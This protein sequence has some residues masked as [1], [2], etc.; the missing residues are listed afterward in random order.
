MIRA[1]RGAAPAI[2]ASAATVMLGLLCLTLGEL[3]SDRSLGPVTAI[4]IACTFVVMLFFLPAFLVL[5]GRW[6]F[7]PRIPRVDQQADIATHGVW[8]RFAAAL[9]RRSRASWIATAVVL[10]ACVAAIS[11][12][13]TDGLSTTDSFTNDPDAV[14]GQR[15]FDAHFDQGTGAP[16][17]IIANA[18]A[19]DKVIAAA[20]AVPGVAT[21]P[22]SVC[23]QVD[24]AKIAKV[25]APVPPTDA[26]DAT[27]ATGAAGAGAA[28]CPPPALQVQPVHGRIAIDANIVHRYDT[29]QAYDTVVALRKAVHAVGGADAKVG[30]ASALNYDIQEASRHDQNLIIPI[31]LVVILLVLGLVLRAV[32]APV[33]L[34]ATVVLS[35]AATLGVSALVFDHVFGFDN[36]DPAFPLFAFVFLVALGIDY[37]IFLMTRVREETMQHGTR[38]GILRGLSV[39]GG[40]ITSAGIVLAATFFVLAVLPLVFLTELGFAVAFGVLLDTIVVRSILVPA[41]SHDIGKKIWWPSKLARAAD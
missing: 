6:V 9:G 16:A 41:L 5:A 25:P 19:A 2:A 24:Y 40:V 12:L 14:L 7:W 21:E 34:I 4:G 38:S 27:G 32:V 31:V 11:G 13:R 39:T 10:L 33:L 35:F 8:G 17:V 3:N 37:N 1:W 23:V 22:G 15:I 36:A 30:G 18:S 28:G 26:T 20:S 29:Q